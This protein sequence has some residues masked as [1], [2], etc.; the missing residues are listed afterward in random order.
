V[1]LRFLMAKESIRLSFLIGPRPGGHTVLRREGVSASPNIGIPFLV[2][3]SPSSGVTY[4]W[5]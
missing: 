1:D 3:L 4:Y 5:E 2:E